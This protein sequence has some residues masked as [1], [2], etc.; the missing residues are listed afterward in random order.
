M[1]PES[2]LTAVAGVA[3]AFIG[4]TGAIF[5]VGRFSKGA[6]KVSERHSLIN[7]L[8]PSVSPGR[9]DPIRVTG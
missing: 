6:W 5:A 9:R 4:F 8:V 7:V 2:L 3:S 1:Q